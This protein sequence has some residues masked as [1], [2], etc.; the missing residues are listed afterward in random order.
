MKS[1]SN[2]SF[3]KTGLSGKNFVLVII[4]QIISLFG[5]SIIRFALPLYI[6]DSSGSSALFAMVSAFSFLP[7]IIMSPVGGI[8]ADRV[9]KQRI[10]V[11]LDFITAALV[12]GFILLS[13]KVDTVALVVAVMMIMYGI[14][15]AYTPAVQ[16]SILLLITED[17]IMPANAAVN[18]VSSFSGLIGPIIG[19]M[20]YGIYG[21]SPIVNIGCACFAI[22]AVMEL[23]IRIPHKKIKSEGSV[24]SIVK[25]DIVQSV[26]FV[27]REKPKMLKVIII[28]S[29]FNMV[30]SSFMVIGLPVIITQTLGISSNYYGITQG[31]MAAG[32]LAGGILAGIMAKKIDMSK[33]YILLVICAASLVPAGVSLL[34]NA[35]AFVSYLILTAM[36]FFAMVFA[37]IFTI[38]MLSYVQIE[39]PSELIG[40]V[41]STLM[42]ISM[43]SQPIGQ[44]IY[45]VVF[46]NAANRQWAIAIAACII[47]FCIA[48]YSKTTFLDF[49]SNTIPGMV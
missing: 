41:V 18:L 33:A 24:L 44:A 25:S 23:F 2:T 37:T 35:P 14:Q 39:T 36:G 11:A 45:G 10:M 22:S 9:N 7:M 48:L 4:G 46:E 20:L 40:K 8:I 42:A 31:A 15:G 6:L 16:A 1:D 34:L 49:K 43:C 5:N 19:G 30:F 13:G 47:S 28:I 32:G 3:E 38:Q 21:L 26:S 17:K 29:L 12:L 27:V